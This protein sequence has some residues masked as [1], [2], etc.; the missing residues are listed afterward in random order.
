MG[1]QQSFTDVSNIIYIGK[2]KLAGLE[3]MYVTKSS[4]ASS[5]M[6]LRR[7]STYRA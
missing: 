6:A 5:K 1:A 2:C 4:S 3:L 7:V